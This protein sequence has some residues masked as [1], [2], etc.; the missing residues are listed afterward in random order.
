MNRKNKIKA[1]VAIAV[2]LA[3]IMPVSVTFANEEETYR[4]ILNVVV[5]ENTISNE[6]RDPIGI[7]HPC[8][9]F[10]TI[11]LWD[12]TYVCLISPL[13][14]HIFTKDERFCINW[15]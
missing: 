14:F 1:I 8:K 13:S 10:S 4:N 2:A 5:E 3:F 15:L 9:I 12:C 11:F 6:Y 7:S